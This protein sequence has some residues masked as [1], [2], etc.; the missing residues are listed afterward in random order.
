MIEKNVIRITSAMILV[1]LQDWG[2][3]GWIQS[4]GGG[5]EGI[6]IHESTGTGDIDYWLITDDDLGLDFDHEDCPGVLVGPYDHDGCP[7]GQGDCPA[8]TVLEYGQYPDPAR[9]IAAIA[10]V[11]CIGQVV[12]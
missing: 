9:M 8:V 2:L 10:E 1:G 5:N 12:K 4:T 3:R 7:Y 6:V 11:L